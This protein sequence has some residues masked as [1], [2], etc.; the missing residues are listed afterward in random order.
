MDKDLQILTLVVFVYR[1]KIKKRDNYQ[2]KAFCF[3]YFICGC[4]GANLHQ[5]CAI[6]LWSELSD[7][8]SHWATHALIYTLWH[9]S[10]IFAF[11][12]KQGN[13]I[14]FLRFILVSQSMLLAVV[15]YSIQIELKVIGRLVY[16]LHLGMDK[17][18]RYLFQSAWRVS[19][20][21]KV[22]S[23]SKD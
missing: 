18:R 22:C 17:E 19:V 8:I 10:F 13:N 9:I 20:I 7:H 6:D 16:Q 5:R 14:F 23:N 1:T 3:R 11:V 4:P 2:Y 21:I 12:L 15:Y